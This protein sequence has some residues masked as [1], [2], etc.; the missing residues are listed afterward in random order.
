[1]FS[2]YMRAPF[3]GTQFGNPLLLAS[4][5]L[6]FTSN[7]KQERR[8]AGEMPK[9]EHLF[10]YFLIQETFPKLQVTDTKIPNLQSSL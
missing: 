9:Y 2:D 3:L 10:I 7:V 5:P 1:M 8:L 6:L 4:N